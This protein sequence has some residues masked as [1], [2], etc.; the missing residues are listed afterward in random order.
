[1]SVVVKISWSLVVPR[2]S[3]HIPTVV[4]SL[5]WSIAFILQ[6][7]EH[8]MFFLTYMLNSFQALLKGLLRDLPPFHHFQRVADN[9]SQL[10]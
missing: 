9:R 6:I 10:S 3:M 5:S 1:M 8:P 7:D 4:S 2:N